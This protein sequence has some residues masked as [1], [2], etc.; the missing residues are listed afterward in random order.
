MVAGVSVSV[1]GPDL[2]VSATEVAVMFT[3][4][5]RPPATVGAVYRPF[6]SIVPAFGVVTAHVTPVLVPAFV[7]VAL[8]CAV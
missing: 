5:G 6:A 2:L 8:N 7:T 1:P 3:V 4:D